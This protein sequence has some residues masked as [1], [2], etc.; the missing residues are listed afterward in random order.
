ML[1]TSR[2][3]R[4]L[5]FLIGVSCLICLCFACHKKGGESENEKKSGEIATKIIENMAKPDQEM[6]ALLS[7]K[8]NK[9][10]DVIEKIVDQ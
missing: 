4:N 3:Y 7:L 8:Y 5:F 6:V 1:H 2:T 9:H 10:L